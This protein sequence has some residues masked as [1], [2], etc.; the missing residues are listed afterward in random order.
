MSP[1]AIFDTDCYTRVFE[2]SNSGSTRP[3][4]LKFANAEVPS[5]PTLKRLRHEYAMLQEAQGPGVVSV[6][7]LTQWGPGQA[8]V[9]ERWG[10]G[11]L[12]HLL[13]HGPLPLETSLHLGAALASALGQVHRKGLI[14][15]DIK[16]QKISSVEKSLR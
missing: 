13:Q 14:H 5:E 2:A 12:D 16:P 8:L 9:M 6:V 15:R 1:A 3:L 7:D 10:Q 11:S 4:V